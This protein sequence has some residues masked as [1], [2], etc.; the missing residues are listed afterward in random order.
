MRRTTAQFGGNLRGELIITIKKLKEKIKREISGRDANRFDNIPFFLS[1]FLFCFCFCFCSPTTF[2][3]FRQGERRHG[4]EELSDAGIVD[5]TNV[6]SSKQPR[7]R[8]TPQVFL[9][10]KSSTP[11]IRL[12]RIFTSSTFA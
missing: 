10:R 9:R 6:R 5:Q 8:R 7:I 12:S 11:R 1:F 3:G 2:P 4:V